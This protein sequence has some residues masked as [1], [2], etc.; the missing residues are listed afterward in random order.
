MAGDGDI[1]AH[2]QTYGSVM[3]MLKWGGVA[4]FFVAAV[5]I[6]LIAP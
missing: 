5:V 6:W 4:C 2:E 1:K 3:S